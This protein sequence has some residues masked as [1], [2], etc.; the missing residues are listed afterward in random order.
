MPQLG[1]C[2]FL[3]DLAFQMSPS[4]ANQTSLP[5]MTNG[6]MTVVDA[7]LAL[8]AAHGRGCPAS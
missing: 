6:T 1:P 7:Q 8:V 2:V 5:W 4:K 3:R